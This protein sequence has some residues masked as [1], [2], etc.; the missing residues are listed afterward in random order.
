M[1]RLKIYFAH[2]TKIDYKNLIYRD[3]INSQICLKHE[4]IL[5]YTEEYKTRY[6][7]DLMNSA[8]LII[9]ETS[10]PTLLLKYELYLLKK[11][12]KP[13][14]Y[15]SL[16]NNIHKSLTKLVPNIEYTSENKTYIQTIED[17]II[18]NEQKIKEESEYSDIVLG[19][20]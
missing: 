18:T 12:N 5:P 14:L 3:V 4:F 17:F 20:L 2:S 8:D 15:L 7:K 19:E 13:I 10:N 6:V 9:V 16:E 11:I 1:K